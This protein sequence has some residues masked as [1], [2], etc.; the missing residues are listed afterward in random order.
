MAL[1]ILLLILIALAALGVLGFILKVAFGVAIGVFLAMLGLGA[2]IA[3]RVRRA[4]RRAMNP[5]TTAPRSVPGPAAE[6][7]PMQGSSE[8]TVLRPDEPDSGPAQ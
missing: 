5:P 4:W 1:L 6:P 7:S 8:V 3:W 2:F